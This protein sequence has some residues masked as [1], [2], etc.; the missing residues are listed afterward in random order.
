MGGSIA[1]P[2]G[3]GGGLIIG[4]ITGLFTADAHYAELN[5][6]IQSEQAKDKELEAQIEQEIERQRELEAQLEKV[7]D[8]SDQK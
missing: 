5:A 2:Y 7:G 4:L 6:Q 3:A 1:G 8:L